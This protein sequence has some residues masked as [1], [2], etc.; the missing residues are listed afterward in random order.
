MSEN[1]LGDGCSPMLARCVSNLPRLTML[2]LAS[3]DLTPA[4]F[5]HQ[6]STLT[7]AF[8]RTLILTPLTLW[9]ILGRLYHTVFSSC[10]SVV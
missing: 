3:C 4:L 2:Q 10:C 8:Q 5:D 9:T 1:S 6:F 7:D